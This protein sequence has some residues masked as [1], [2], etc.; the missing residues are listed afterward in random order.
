M[1]FDPTGT[2]SVQNNAPEGIVACD[3]AVTG[4]EVFSPYA[5]SASLRRLLGD[6]FP[7]L[8]E[9]LRVAEKAAMDWFANKVD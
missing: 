8:E 4:A 7:E 2:G 1:H 9:R 3:N 6:H 5:A